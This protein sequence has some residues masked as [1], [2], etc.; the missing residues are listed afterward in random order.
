VGIGSGY[1]KLSISSSGGS[2]DLSGWEFVNLQLGVDFAVGSSVKIGPW[3]GFSLG[4][5]STG[6]ISDSTN[7]VSQDL[8][9]RKTLHEWL[10][11]GVRL[12]FLP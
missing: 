9:S 10:M 5:Y 6:S 3:V 7:G 1:E 12:V 11:I 4:Q 8:G 2:F